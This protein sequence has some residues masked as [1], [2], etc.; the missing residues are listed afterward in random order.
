MKLRGDGTPIDDD[1]DDDDMRNL[2][3]DPHWMSASETRVEVY[4]D[5]RLLP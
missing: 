3:H 1:D 2:K 4:I 5:V